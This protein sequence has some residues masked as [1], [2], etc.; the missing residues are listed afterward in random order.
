[1]AWGSTYWNIRLR[2]AQICLMQQENKSQ[3]PSIPFLFS[4]LLTWKI[5]F[6]TSSSKLVVV[7]PLCHD[8]C[9]CISQ[10]T[11]HHDVHCSRRS[12]LCILWIVKDLCENEHPTLHQQLNFGPTMLAPVVYIV[13]ITKIYLCLFIL[14]RLLVAQ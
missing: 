11:K 12:S 3:M 10:T 8:R 6:P 5:D 2:P 1:M 14:V 4:F 7:V 13:K 9:I